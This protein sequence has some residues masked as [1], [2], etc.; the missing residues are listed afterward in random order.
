MTQ[1][2]VFGASG[3]VGRLVV[4]EL[5]GRGHNVVAFVHSQKLTEKDFVRDS[6]H[7]AKATKNIR[8]VQGDIYNAV[9][10][11]A[12]LSGSQAVISVLGS[13]GTKR[14][15]ILCSAMR[16]I[17]PAMEQQHI[18]RIVSLTGHDARTEG[19][20][21]DQFHILCSAWSPAKFYTMV[22]SILAY[23]VKVRWI[24]QSCAHQ[25]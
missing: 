1:I 4:A 9:Q 7:D 6:V 10:V 19:D 23:F 25:L 14:K 24:G 12:A 11:A 20:N 15:D 17:I 18:Q 5:L 2:T 22:N 13:W 3:K 21:I 8:I 16:A